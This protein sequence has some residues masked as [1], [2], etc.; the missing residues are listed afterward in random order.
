MK[1]SSIATEIGLLIRQIRTDKGLSQED[2]AFNCELH[3]TYIGSLERGEKVP[4]ILTL[5]KISN[6]LEI[7]LSELFKKYEKSHSK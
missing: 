1:K 7:S 3:R 6:A 4:T 2:L 5:E